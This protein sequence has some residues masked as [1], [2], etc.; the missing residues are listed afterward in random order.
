M[1]FIVCF[2]VLVSHLRECEAAKLP[3]GVLV[4]RRVDFLFFNDGFTFAFNSQ[5]ILEKR[6][7]QNDR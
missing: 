1:Y 6:T 2:S 7:Q 4:M 5:F 3:L